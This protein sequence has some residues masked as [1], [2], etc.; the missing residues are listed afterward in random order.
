[1][2]VL[3]TVEAF[4]RNALPFRRHVSI[5]RDGEDFIVAFQPD[6]VVVFRHAEASELRRMC[7]RLR[8]KIVSD[9]VPDPSDLAS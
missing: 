2:S 7:H 9:T 8:W 4:R 6:N 1:M 5:S 3:D